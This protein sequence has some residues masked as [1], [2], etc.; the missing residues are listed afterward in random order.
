MALTQANRFIGLETPLGGDVLAV[1]SASYTEQ[2][3]HL[4]QIE[5]DI[6]SSEEKAAS[7]EDIIGQS[8]TLRM[9][10]GK[11]QK[12]YF[13]GIVS[14]FVQ[15]KNEGRYAHYRATVVP[16]LWLLTRSSDCRIFQKMSIPEIIEKVFKDHGLD[17]YTLSL[18]GDYQPWDYCVQYRETDF[19][20]VSRL[21]EQ[22]GIYYFFEHEDGKHTLVLA[23]APA[24]HCPN[25]GYETIIYRPPTDNHPFDRECVTDWVVEK[26]LQ[27][28]AYAL[29]DFNFVS[30]KTNLFAK[31]TKDRSHAASAFEVYDYPGEYE[32]HP[33]GESYAKVRLEEL[34][35][36]YETCHAQATARGLCSGFLFTLQDHP[37]EDQNREY[38]V[39]SVSCQMDA[40]DFEAS[41][42]GTDFFS[43]SFIA[44][45]SQSP[46]RPARTTPKPLIQGPQTAMV[47][48]PS[49]EEI[50]TDEYGRVK[51]QFHWDRQGKADENSSCWVRVSQAWAG[52]GWGS[53]HIPRIGQEV[54]VEFLEGDPDRPIVTGRVYNAQTTVPYELPGNKT[55]SGIKSRSTM[56]GGEGNFNEIRFEDKIGSEEVYVQAEKDLNLLVKNSKSEDVG[57]DKTISVGG[58]HSEQITGN[59]SQTV[60][61]AKSETIALAKA[62]TI[63]AAYQIS[64]G[65]AMNTTVGISKSEEVGAFRSGVVGGGDTQKIGGKQDISVG[66]DYSLAVGKDLA[67]AAKEKGSISISKDLGIATEKNLS[68]KA[69]ESILIQSD[70]DIT[71]KAG[72]ATITLKKDGTIEVKGAKINVKGSGDVKIKGSKVAIN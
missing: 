11:D 63:G 61:Q 48:G 70:K 55:Q 57:A 15:T 13:N 47:V 30:P 52:K 2:I 25:P 18:S 42:L 60:S 46:F 8:V 1:R 21:M 68:V 7:F 3:S 14:R 71:V 51:L 31:S 56:K 40:G 34:Q 66:K 6:V 37:R 16:W 36:N 4:F 39:T 41:D 38:L 58:N 28:G 59:M 35:A 23:D 29:K 49:G 50:H 12:R 26:E 54:I 72:D 67:I 44:G 22:E 69:T 45:D 33:D 32:E 17:Q 62:L 5:L 43:C 19:N 20:F 64:V 27:P 65:A 53:M 10:A 24:A 9:N